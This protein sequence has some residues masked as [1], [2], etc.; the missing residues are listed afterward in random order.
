[1]K[2]SSFFPMKS[3]LPA[4]RTRTFHS[5]GTVLTGGETL[6]K[7]EEGGWVKTDREP[8]FSSKYYLFNTAN[9]AQTEKI[10]VTWNE[11]F[12]YR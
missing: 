11:H 2:L 4:R 3:N 8:A 5:L 10:S 7:G 1:M 9:F 12:Q 6:T